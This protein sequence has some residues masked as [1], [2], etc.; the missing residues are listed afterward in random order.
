VIPAE[1]RFLIAGVTVGHS[2]EYPFVRSGARPLKITITD[3]AAAA[4]PFDLAVAV[5]RGVT[6]FPYPLPR[7]SPDEFLVDPLAGWGEALNVQSSPASIEI[8]ALPS[9][10]VTVTQGTD[11]LGIARWGEIEEK[12]EV[13]MPR[14]RLELL[15]T[16]RN[17]VR[18][19]VVD[20]ETGQP[21]PCRV[22][23]RSSDGIPYQP[24]GHQQRVN[25]NMD[26]W[27]IDVGGDVRLGSISYAYI[28]GTC[29]GWLPRGEVLVDVARGF[30]Y[31]P[32]RMRVTIEPGQQELTL[33]LKRWCNMNA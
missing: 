29:L 1:P 16:G 18:T 15:D 9:A 21:V 22:H 33:R 25:S 20:D 4:R 5:D 23:F 12:K 26:T 6:T 30:E 10:T 19:T 32:L 8:A 31:E 2:N 14:M 11:V 7:Q 3:P 27:H 24:H 28:D 17:W 13:E